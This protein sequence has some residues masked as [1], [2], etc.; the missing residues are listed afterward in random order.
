MANKKN[1]DAFNQMQNEINNIK[2]T[3]LHGKN[4][5][6]MLSLNQ[7]PLYWYEYTIQYAYNSTNGILTKRLFRGKAEAAK[8]FIEGLKVGLT[9]TQV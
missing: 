1:A 8:G 9:V 6:L 3:L 7:I 2:S 4:M 5:K